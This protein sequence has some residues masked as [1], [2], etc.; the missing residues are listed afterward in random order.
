[1]IKVLLFD[2]SRTLIHPKQISYSGKLNDLYRQIIS[3]KNYSIF[4][5]FYLNQELLDFLK[6]LKDKYT[7]A[8]FTT[9]IIQNDPAIKST[10][11]TIFSHTFVAN[12]LG[13][14]KKDPKGYLIIADKLNMKAEEILFIDDLSQNIE[15][16][17]K[18]GLQTIQFISNKQLIEKLRNI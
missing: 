7:L 9:D 18:S 8:I 12:D 5:Y 17:K 10:L 14:S 4:N 6:L 11:D 16:A 1:M 15:A 3:N 2:F 13:I